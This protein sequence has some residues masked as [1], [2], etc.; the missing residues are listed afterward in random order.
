MAPRSAAGAAEAGRGDAGRRP[1]P[2]S[3]LSP[4]TGRAR[5]AREIVASL[6]ADIA[7]GR[8]PR[9]ARLPGEPDLARHFGVSQPTVREAVRALDLMGLLDVRHGSGVYVTGDVAGFLDASLRVLLQVEQVGI[10]EVLDLRTLLGGYSARQAAEH[11]TPD[12]VAI[13]TAYLDACDNPPDGAA[14]RDMVIPA[15]AFQ[16]AVSAAARNPLLFAIESFLVKLIIQLQLT[17]LE[18]HGSA[19]WRERIASFGTD[20]RRLLGFIAA[21]D[22]DGAA[23]AMNMYLRTQFAQFAADPELAAAGLADPFDAARQLDALLPDLRP[24]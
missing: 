2:A 9:G 13:M 14:P 15:A 5:A 22:G 16:L 23:S 17:A 12:E 1:A 20:R 6:Q 11:V 7:T 19:F 21:R 3:S 18:H 8:L 24:R 4:I 10:V